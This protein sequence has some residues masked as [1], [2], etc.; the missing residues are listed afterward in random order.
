[1]VQVLKR[2]AL[3]KWFF[4]VP[5]MYGANQM[6]IFYLTLSFLTIKVSITSAADDTL[7]DIYPNF[8]KNKVWY[9]MRIVCRHFVIFEKAA[10]FEI[11]ICKL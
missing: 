4:C 11:V 6:S 2:T 7:C 3:A 10:K 9:F 5:L 1:M 8:R